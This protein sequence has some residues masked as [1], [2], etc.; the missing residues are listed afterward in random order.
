V[1]IPASEPQLSA[2]LVRPFLRLLRGRGLPV[3]AM[4][5][6]G[7]S[8][9]DPDTRIPHRVAIS[10]HKAASRGTADPAIGL[11]AAEHIERGDFDVLEFAAMSSATIR[12]A[13]AT[14]NRYLRLVHDAAEFTLETKGDKS[15]WRFRVLPDLPLPPTAVEYFMAIFVILGRQYVK[16]GDAL[17]H[18][19][20]LFTHERPSDVSVHERIFGPTVL[21][22]QREN[23]LVFPTAALERPMARA[24]PPLKALLEGMADAALRKLPSTGSLTV[25][26]RRLLAAELRGGDPSIE[27]LS[28]KL[29]TTPRT[30]RRWL[31]DAGTTHRDILD[32][33]R[34][35][36]AFQY[37][38]EPT[39]AVREVA[40]LLGYSSAG[41]FLRAFK[42]WAGISATEYRK[43][44]RR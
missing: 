13:I 10:L 36:L 12:E 25:N 42:R 32:Q 18:E 7:A 34:K 4:N 21:F 33:L 43:E 15:I 27:L 6:G 3:E 28:R 1:P 9:E 20:V 44:R 17:A 29:H 22:G 2:R 31:A 24:D 38:R 37:L 40:F 30:L 41:P 35:E 16:E 8:L 19:T 5:L 39:L 23:A 14:A 26:V 11:H